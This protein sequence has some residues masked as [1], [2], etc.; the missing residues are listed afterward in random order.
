MNPENKI[1]HAPT[2][3][4]ADETSCAQVDIAP[5][6]PGCEVIE[7]DE[8]SGQQ[9]W[10]DSVFVQDFTDSVL[11]TNPAPLSEHDQRQGLQRPA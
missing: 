10:S 4:P 1:G 5:S 9:E 8:L 2:A 6:M 3:W 11:A 7:Y